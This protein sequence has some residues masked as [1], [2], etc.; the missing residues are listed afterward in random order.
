MDRCGTG[1]HD[2]PRAA[3]TAGMRRVIDALLDQCDALNRAGR[4]LPPGVRDRRLR[5][6]TAVIVGL[7]ERLAARLRRQDPI[8]G[9]VKLSKPD[10]LAALFAA[11]RYW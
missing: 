8:A 10:A 4:Q 1:V 2:I 9:R 5:L 11:L 6:E 7:A 3:A